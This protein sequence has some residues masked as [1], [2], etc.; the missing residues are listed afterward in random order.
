MIKLK[1]LI[2]EQPVVSADGNAS[3]I[4][5]FL[6]SNGFEDLKVDWK[7][8]PST[9]R[10]VWYYIYKSDPGNI[11][12]NQLWQ[13][14]KDEKDLPETDVNP[15]Y[16]PVMA[17]AVA[18]KINSIQTVSTTTPAPLNSR[19]TSIEDFKDLIKICESL[20]NVLDKQAEKY[21][22]PFRGVFNDREKE[23]K[24]WFISATSTAYGPILDRLSKS[25]NRTIRDNVNNIIYIIDRFAN[26]IGKQHVNSNLTYTITIIH[27][28]DS[29]Q[30]KTF[31]IRFDYL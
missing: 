25:L 1:T 9:A 3:S 5:K 18:K 13:K 10:A 20:Y 23:A 21:F 4:Q 27:P 17:A 7:F 19:D 22:K 11:T 24:E 6:K 2:N 28:I 8:G 16:G 29:Q 30:S 26:Y 31:T 14:M 12:V 15:G